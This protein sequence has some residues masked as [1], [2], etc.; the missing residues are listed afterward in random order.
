MKRPERRLKPEEHSAIVRLYETRY[1]AQGRCHET[2]GWGSR[3]DQILRFKM[4]LRGLRPKGKSILDVGCGLGDLVPFLDDLTGGDYDYS[5]VDI[6]PKLIEDAAKAFGGPK[7]RFMAGDILDMD[8]PRA[9]LCVLSGALN[10]RIEDNA[11]HARTML[12]RMFALSKE[13]VSVNFLSTHVDFQNPRNFHYDPSEM[14]AFAKTL[15]KWVALYHDY[16]LWEFT[17]QM[18]REAL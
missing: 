2:V 17:L 3:A 4:L 5:G 14:L 16:P 11:G 6:A 10:F 15:T 13:A 12:S 9:D 1:D 8:L 18:R 7:R